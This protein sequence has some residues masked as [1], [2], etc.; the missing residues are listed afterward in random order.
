MTWV[1]MLDLRKDPRSIKKLYAYA[2]VA[3]AEGIDFFYF[4]PGRVQL[5]DQTI[6][7]WFYEN[8]QWIER[9]VPFP[10]VIIN[11][12]SQANNEQT[13][14]IIEYLR[15]TIPFTSY[16]VGNKMKVYE[17]LQN[18]KFFSPYLLPTQD[19]LDN[20]I[21][22]EFLQQ[23]TRVIVKPRNGRKGNGVTYIEQITNDQFEIIE[24]ST[25]VVLNKEQLHHY[26]RDLITDQSW[27][28]QRYNPSKTK[29]GLSYDI[30]IHVQ[31]NGE[32]KWIITTIYPRVGNY[33]AIKAN[34]SAGGFTNYLDPFLQQEFGEQSFDIR[35]MLERFGLSLALHMDEIYGVSYDELGI[36]VGL[37]ENLRIW[38]YEINW[39]PGC[40]PTFYLELDVVRHSLQYAAF[41]AQQ[42]KAL[43]RSQD[44]DEHVIFQPLIIAITGSAGK[45]TA[46][47]MVASILEQRWKIFKSEGNQNT[48]TYTELH[49]KQIHAGHRAAVLEYG[50]A[51]SGIIAK[52]C[53]I[54]PPDLSVITNIGTA[55]V[56][57][58]GG[59]IEDVARTKSEIIKGMNPSG[60]LFLNADDENSKLLQTQDFKGK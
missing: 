42:K 14:A 58:L 44:I 50:M 33:G 43:L 56:D 52:H 16:P 25:P 54:L 8:G 30:R 11:S 27:I 6:L 19:I 31:K 15:D 4:S 5:Q 59:R 28:V 2:S 13:Q 37:D 47:E 48:T 38:L 35:K 46:K 1:G 55:H 12:K 26:L 22:F 39:H 53:S 40:P 60:T 57:N 7:G 34:I 36:D 9:K 18:G 17:N 45:S 23:F 51:Y 32:G 21:V 10:H 29:H 49:A 24:S 3:K 20:S 41:L